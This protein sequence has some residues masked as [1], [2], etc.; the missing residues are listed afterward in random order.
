MGVKYIIR[1]HENEW[2]TEINVPDYEGAPIEVL[3]VGQ[4]AG[5]SQYDEAEHV[6][7]SKWN[8]SFY[9]DEDLFD[10]QTCNDLEVKVTVY[11]YNTIYWTGFLIA[12]GIKQYVRDIK[13][14]VDLIATDGLNNMED[15]KFTHSEDTDRSP[16]YY[17]KRCLDII[18]NRLKIRY[19]L[20]TKSVINL[21]GDAFADVVQLNRMELPL[22]KDFDCSFVLENIL[23]SFNLKMM[24]SNG[25]WYIVNQL[26]VQNGLME[27]FEDDGERFTE[28]IFF[29]PEHTMGNDSTIEVRKGF[30]SVKTVY[31]PIR[32]INVI[33]NG[34][35]NAFEKL[36]NGADK[37]LYWYSD[38]GNIYSDPANDKRISMRP[39]DDF[40]RPERAA[41]LDGVFATGRNYYYF[42]NSNGER[43]IPIDGKNLYK[44][45]TI[46]FRM[47]PELYPEYPVGNDKAGQIDW[48]SKPFGMQVN[49]TVEQDG[50]IEKWY[51]NEFGWWVRDTQGNFRMLSSSFDGENDTITMRFEGYGI[52]NQQLRIRQYIEDTPNYVEDTIVTFPS[53]FQTLD[54]TLNYIV[55]Y[56]ERFTRVN[57]D[58]IRFESADRTWR[59]P[60]ASIINTSGVTTTNYINLIVDQAINGDVIEFQFQS[61]ANQGR[62]L[63]PDPGNISEPLPDGNGRLSFIFSQAK[64][65]RT[66]VDNLQFKFDDVKETYNMNL[67]DNKNSKEDLELRISSSFT[68]FNLT[69][70]S[71]DFTSTEDYQMFVR[72]GITA[73]LTEHYGRDFLRLNARPR[74]ILSTTYL[75]E[76]RPYQIVELRGIKFVPLS[77]QY[78]SETNQT[79]GV[80]IELKDNNIDNIEVNIS[81]GKTDN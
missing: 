16:L 43:F 63:L 21:D 55:N 25:Y 35:F 4:R 46:S 3:G 24:Q 36:P 47:M 26:D 64:G 76:M 48:L 40:G 34:D 44:D 68:G 22:Y 14:S 61:K 66:T 72:N 12:D 78:N 15:L 67:P 77:M 80:F 13:S 41:V 33:P 23:K 52:A 74:C 30:G 53:N 58:T 69:S 2:R 20:S 38:G 7:S 57:T 17:I 28:Y 79:S 59:D 32:D 60:E 54:A 9:T 37:P 42:Q 73:T 45:F 65:V 75:G 8:F 62:I 11:R 1:Y 5:E 70:Y 27:G 39:F 10:L 18:D 31:N 29:T 51:L 19:A 50:N 71:T 6:M 56:D 81:D 49:Y